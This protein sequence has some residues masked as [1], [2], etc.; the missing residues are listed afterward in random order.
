M[1]RLE[2]RVPPLLVGTVFAAA[3]LALA[4]L[5]PQL[6]VGVPFRSTAVAVLLALG[7][8]VAFA[9]VVA[10]RRQRTTVNPLN[11]HASSSVVTSG[12]YR[13]SRNPMYLG[14][15]LVLAA[16]AVHLSNAASALLLPGFVMYM[17]RFQIEPEERT[18]LA[19]FGATFAQYMSRVRRW[20]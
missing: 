13:V 16:W 14:F 6:S 9:G 10:F 5:M 1:P 4:M 15:L 7:V 11:P 19:K 3:M 2:L 8:T 20:V 12:I 18:L 17:N